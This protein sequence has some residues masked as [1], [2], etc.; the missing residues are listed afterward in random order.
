MKTFVALLRG[1]NVS[2]QKQISMSVLKNLC[3][4]LSF[5]EV[6]TYLQSGNVVFKSQHTNPQDL[7]KL[8][9]VQ[10]ARDLG[11]DVKVVVLDK[12][13]IKIV[14]DSNVLWARLGG[15][16]KLHH[17]VFLDHPI[18]Q[19]RFQQL[20]L[21][22]QSGEEVF[23]SGKTIF[24]YCPNGYGRTKLNNNFFEKGLEISATTRNW[25]TVLALIEMCA[26]FP[27]ET[28]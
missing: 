1:I 7:S 5:H 28:K 16:E 12:K 17:C 9:S 3:E 22:I 11:H 6:K 2:G 8:L 13:E 21:P 4:T 15:E 24:L 10:I 26:E 19:E 23:F 27:D 20:K 18:T 14:A 25:R